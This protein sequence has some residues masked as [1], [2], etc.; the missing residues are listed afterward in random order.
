MAYDTF[1]TAA[2][3]A[4]LDG[5]LRGRTLLQVEALPGRD[6]RLVFGPRREP[7]FVVLA[8]EPFPC[9]YRSRPES[10]RLLAP[11]TLLE[12]PAPGLGQFARVLEA[13][14]AGRGLKGVRHL[15]WERVVEFAFSPREGLRQDLRTP[16]LVH[17][18]APKP[19]RVVLLDGDRAVAATWPPAED[20]RLTRG[21]VYSPP[22][23]RAG[24]S[25]ADL[26][27]QWKTFTGAPAEAGSPEPDGCGRTPS[28]LRRLTRKLL[29]AAPALG[30]V[31]AEEVA[32]RALAAVKGA[33][34]PRPGAPRTV[35][36]VEDA[37]DAEVLTALR[38]ALS[39]MVSLYPAG[40]WSPAV[41]VS[42]APPH[43]VL[44]V[45]AVPVEV[46]DRSVLLPSRDVGR[47]LE[48]W[49][50]SRRLESRLDAVVVRTRR[51]LRSALRRTRRKLDR[52]T[53][54]QAEAQRAE[55]F[56][57][58]GELLLANLSRISRG[59]REVTVTDYDGRPLTIT[60][61]P[62]LT[63]TA[64]ARRF[65]DRYRKARRAASR[66]DLLR[67]TAD[68]LAWL[69]SVAYDLDQVLAHRGVEPGAEDAPAPAAA[70][71][72][73]VT[74]RLEGAAET[75]VELHSIERALAEAGYAAQPGP[76]GRQTTA[77]GRRPR[78]P[79]PLRFVTADGLTVL[80]GR[81]ARENELLSLK[82]ARPDDLWFHARGCPGSHVLL[83]LD[84]EGRR[85]QAP[86]ERS[87]LQAAA[88]AVHLSARRGEAKAEVDYTEA[89]HLR[90]P[91]GA[92]RGL[93][94]YDR[95]RTLLVDTTKVP[96]PAPPHPDGGGAE[97]R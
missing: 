69:E 2:T 58:K 29:S 14:L 6:L 23:A 24:L 35:E 32:R 63:P 77:A 70:T 87:V 64:N 65:F 54:D 79:T 5:L 25:P 44:D 56:R 27:Q 55:E 97:D 66:A 88:L 51:T 47:A 86:P 75:L 21:A 1:L 93:V 92:P 36:G 41:I 22:P 74:R 42:K 43:A 15:P 80:A 83:R 91:K 67:S 82:L 4:E 39:D 78:R 33:T 28:P 8:G 84:P 38:R 85:G 17:E 95:H 52:R 48:T 72:A 62:R 57:L 12:D 53:A 9:V 30:P 90:R 76:G 73:A 96:L 81:T 68:H 40:P 46:G 34:R 59:A 94:V 89:R 19:A 60:L 26:L 61:D 18:A 31:A 37:E 16:F 13:R 50:L 11:E 71:L 7:V 45:T 49:H 20:D 3:A 10:G